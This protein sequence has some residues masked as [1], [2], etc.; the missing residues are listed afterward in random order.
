MPDGSPPQSTD[1]NI[2]WTIFESYTKMAW[3]V[4]NFYAKG[5]AFFLAINA[6]VFGY[7]LQTNLPTELQ[8]AILGF[9]AVVGL[10]F[11]LCSIGY[12]VWA[13][14]VFRTVQSTFLGTDVQL[15]EKYG[16]ALNFA[17]G[18]TLF[19]LFALGALSLNVLVIVAHV[20]LL[21]TR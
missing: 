20:L 21:F 11:L 16:V 19:G 4:T 13:A 5:I 3:E 14:G 7:V 15:S 12:F 1:A 17:R 10:L 8:R 6:A 18:R 9:A 2:E